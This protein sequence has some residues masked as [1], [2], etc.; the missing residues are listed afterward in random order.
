MQLFTP[1]LFSAAA[2]S[3]AA[4]CG[5]AAPA[6]AQYSRYGDPYNRVLV[7][8]PSSYWGY[9]YNPYASMLHGAAEVTRANGDYFLK[10]QEAARLREEVRQAKLV[11]RRLQLEHWAWERDFRA[12]M[13]KRERE[14]IHQAEIQRALT[15]P[16]QTEIL[17]AIPH[18]RI[19]DELRQLPDLPREG[20]TRVE[21]E[22][23]A[24]IHSSVD[25]RGNLGL[26]KDDR[27]FWPELLTRSDFR[28]ICEKIEQLLARA[29]EQALKPQSNFRI[30][31]KLLLELRQHEADCRE[32]LDRE[33]RNPVMEPGWNERHFIE[34]NRFLKEELHPAVLVLEKPNAGLFL[35]PLRGAT[36]A[37]LVAHMKKEG[38]R[39]APATVGCD[40]AYISLHRALAEELKRLQQA[41]LFRQKP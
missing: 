3:V 22:W 17:Y 9:T 32:H 30:D 12:E 5:F 6:D 14:R 34:A 1:R 10:T 11:T 39:F 21:P 29:K 19:F 2:A 18:N 37:E 16:P 41:E 31:T 20:S 38:I 7:A 36:V 23:L 28:Q 26:L 40:R 8:A 15:D 25:G 4:L 33:W 13:L 24:H 35:N 27:I